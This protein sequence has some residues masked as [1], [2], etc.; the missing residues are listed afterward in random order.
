MAWTLQPD[1]L[2]LNHEYEVGQTV[3]ALWASISSFVK[4]DWCYHLH[5]TVPWTD[6][7]YYVKECQKSK[8]A[9]GLFVFWNVTTEGHDILEPR[10]KKKKSI[11]GMYLIICLSA[12]PS[13]DCI[14]WRLFNFLFQ[15]SY[16]FLAYN[17]SSINVSVEKWMRGKEPSLTDQI[18][19]SSWNT[20]HRSK[21]RFNG[22][23]LNTYYMLSPAWSL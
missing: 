3:H 18:K 14:S 1:F 20:G 17:K 19:E 22:L 8:V 10:L 6:L 12:S 16:K 15:L 23:L 2:G 21:F 11:W 4:W 7:V 9:V 5:F 13:E